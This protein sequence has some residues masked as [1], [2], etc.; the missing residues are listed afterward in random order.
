MPIMYF[1]CTHTHLL[2]SFVLQMVSL[3]PINYPLS[4]S[5]FRV[6]YGSLGSLTNGYTTE[7]NVS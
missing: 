7:Q 6:D 2:A 1:N 4:V 5:G 3:F